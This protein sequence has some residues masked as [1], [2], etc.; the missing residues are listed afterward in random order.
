MSIA[1]L[2]STDPRLVKGQTGD[3]LA[4]DP[5][6]H[7]V[8]GTKLADAIRY[9]EP[10]RYWIGLL[11]GVPAGVAV[12]QPSDSALAVA[13]MPA[14]VVAAIAD[15]VDADGVAMPGVFGP[16]GTASRFAEV[17]AGRH[18]VAAIQTSAERLFE[19][20]DL[21][22]PTGVDGTLRRAAEADR[23]LLLSW[24][25]GFE[26]GAD[27]ASSNPAA[28]FVTRRLAAGDVW[29]WEDDGPVSMAAR[30]EAV[31]GV[32]RIQAVNTP[33]E[34]RARGYASAG[35]AA[36]SASV[37]E[38]GLRCVLN[39][40]VNNVAANSVYQRLGYRAVSH[41]LRYQLG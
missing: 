38:Q 11:D 15:A 39:A 36:L 24:L 25:P 5:V 12:Q 2:S 29:I 35:V 31:A 26:A 9:R 10:G 21:R 34:Q 7:N 3:L 33:P 40:N 13:P 27:W 14:G 22:F 16:A 18:K 37:L 8:V 17:W 32:S 23:G 1:V 41:M 4:S 30:T 28:V 19:V 20:R 6:G